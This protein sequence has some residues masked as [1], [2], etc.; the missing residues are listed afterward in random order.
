MKA[1][2]TRDSSMT[3]CMASKMTVEIYPMHSIM[4][5]LRK[6]ATEDESDRTVEDPI[7]LL[8]DTSS[9]YKIHF[10]WVFKDGTGLE[11]AGPPHSCGGGQ[12]GPNLYRFR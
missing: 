1:Q 8:L 2:V 3:N 5:E 12:L 6:K 10:D 11:Q 4:S 7:W 9:C